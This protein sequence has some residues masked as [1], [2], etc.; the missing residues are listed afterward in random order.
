[1]RFLSSF[2]SMVPHL[3]LLG[4]KENTHH[5]ADYYARFFRVPHIQPETYIAPPRYVMVVDKVEDLGHFLDENLT[6]AD[7]EKFHALKKTSD[8]HFI[9]WVL[10]HY[11]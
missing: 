8:N 9:S 5:Y 10:Q 1:M 11:T 3:V 6:I 4:N 2:L 7:M